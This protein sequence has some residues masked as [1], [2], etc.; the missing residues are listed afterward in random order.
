MSVHLAVPGQSL[1]QLLVNRR[2]THL[3]ATQ[4]GSMLARWQITGTPLRQRREV[5]HTVA[6]SERLESVL[7]AAYPA[8]V[9][10][11][12]AT[13]Q[14]IRLGIHERVHRP[15]HLD[16]KPDH[17]YFHDDKVT[18]IDL[19]SAAD[20]D[21]ALEIGGLL[22]RLAFAQPL[23]EIDRAAAQ[24]FAMQFYASYRS[25]VPTRWLDNL[26]FYY[27][28]STLQAALH[29]FEHQ[30]PDWPEW[31]ALMLDHA[32]AASRL[33]EEPLAWLAA[34]P[35]RQRPPN[36]RTAPPGGAR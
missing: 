36:F 18:L 31:V 20:A 3:Q 30:K 1:H 34:L 10:L 6:R 9:Q 12:G 7:T 27:A 11:L 24:R 17:I 28:W 26:P 25:R 15:G 19:D 2:E 35:S 4:L 23:Y 21:P 8:G 16:L 14:R 5:A 13:L 32:A 22:A 33:E 29:M